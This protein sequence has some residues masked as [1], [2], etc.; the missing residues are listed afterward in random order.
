MQGSAMTQGNFQAAPDA[1]FVLRGIL[2]SVGAL[3]HPSNHH[4]TI[5][6]DI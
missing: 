2:A 6:H 3:V 1:A 4:P 5:N